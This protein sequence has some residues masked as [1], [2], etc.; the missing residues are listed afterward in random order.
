MSFENKLKV[1]GVVIMIVSMIVLFIFMGCTKQPIKQT[2][3]ND[4]R[5]YQTTD[6]L[7]K[8]RI[9]IYQVQIT[10][11]SERSNININISDVTNLT[12]QSFT[13]EETNY[14]F[15]NVLSNY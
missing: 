5:Q 11:I 9:E 14:S 4:V 6:V 3:Y 15:T 13:N 10:V 7:T 12:I 2:N 8:Q 1:S